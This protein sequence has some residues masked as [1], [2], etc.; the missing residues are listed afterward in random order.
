MYF[1]A[2]HNS[3]IEQ[4]NNAHYNLLFQILNVKCLQLF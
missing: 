1:K 4:Q 3:L 2:G